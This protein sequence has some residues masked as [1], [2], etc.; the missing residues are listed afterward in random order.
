V[1]EGDREVLTD[2]IVL[3]SRRWGFISCGTLANTEFLE[4]QEKNSFMLI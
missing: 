3:K 1:G 4:R 2:A